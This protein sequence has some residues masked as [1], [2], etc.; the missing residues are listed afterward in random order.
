M[1]KSFLG[2]YATPN[3]PETGRIDH[4]TGRTA[5]RLTGP[6]VPLPIISP[7]QAAAN[8]NAWADPL[9]RLALAVKV[10][11]E[12]AERKKVEAEEKRQTASFIR[13]FRH[14]M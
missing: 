9:P 1:S 3:D 4:G 13:R 8:A 6:T 12:T 10:N 11:K 5:N 7:E 2:Y 14:L